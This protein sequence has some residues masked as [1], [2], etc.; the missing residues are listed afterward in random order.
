MARRRVAFQGERGAFSEAAA[1]QLLGES[2][3]PV[4]CDKDELVFDM[5]ENRKADCAVIP[6]ENSLVGS[7]H[8]YYDLL[9]KRNLHVTGETQVRIIHC[10]IVPKGVALKDITKVYSHP[11]ALDQCRNFFDSHPK[12][13]PISYYDTA[14]AVK[15]LA[16]SG[17]RNAAAIAGPFTAELYMGMRVL[18]KSIEDEKSNYTRFLLLQRR[19]MPFKGPAKTS[20][21]F[22]M[23][24]MPGGL[25][26]VLSV[27]AL[28]DI[29][30]TKIESRPVRKK[31][32][33]YHFYLDFIGSVKDE[34][35]KNALDHLAEITHFIR[36]LG[37]YPRSI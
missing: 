13:A 26:K 30:L 6:I 34:A 15:M 4:A 24:N 14:G 2:I 22:S 11:V 20:I 37:S 21:V 19:P 18:R 23:K 32:W 3:T 27:F 25:F 33:Q 10:L 35:V 8:R 36:I 29:D 9:L 17:A 28:R 1:H 5:V 12:I 31:A 7:I 16:D